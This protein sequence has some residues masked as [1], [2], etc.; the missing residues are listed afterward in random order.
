MMVEN[1]GFFNTGE[2]APQHLI[3][4]IQVNSEV[5]ISA[6]VDVSLDATDGFHAELL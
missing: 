5:I 6:I 1:P 4:N 3:N 2:D